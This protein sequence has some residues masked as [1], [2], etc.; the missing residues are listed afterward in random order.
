MT[1]KQIPGRCPLVWRRNLLAISF[2]LTSLSSCS[3][4]HQ[5]ELIPDQPPK[6]KDAKADEGPG[7]AGRWRKV[8]LSN[9]GSEMS[10]LQRDEITRLQAL[11][12][13][14]GSRKPDTDRVITVHE[15]E[16]VSAGLNFYASAH[17]PEAMLL[18]MD[19]NE[20]HRWNFTAIRAWPDL[21]FERIM[22]DKKDYWRRAHLFE[23]GDVLAISEGIGLL[24]IDKDSNLIWAKL[25]GAHHDL[26][27]LPNGD[28]YVLTRRV[29]I[30]PDWHRTVPVRE[31]YISLLDS[32]GNQQNKR[33]SLLTCLAKLH[34]E[35][36]YTWV[37]GNVESEYFD[38]LH[39]N[40]L[41]VLTG[42]AAHLSPSFT[43]G[44]ILVALR[45]PSLLAVVDCEQEKFVWY[46]AS[47]EPKPVRDDGRPR[48]FFKYQH[49]PQIIPGGNMLFFDNSGLGDQSTIWEF[50]PVTHEVHWF[51]RGT[52]RRPFYTE[53]CGTVQRLPNGNTLI[54]ESDNGRV[55]E[56]TREHNIVWEF[57]NP[58]RAGQDGKY[59][60]M[61]PEMVRLPPQ[62]P[63]P[64]ARGNRR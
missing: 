22:S 19:G 59:I 38:I 8:R 61:V 14:A 23:N 63:T 18:D 7:Q 51:F 64:W 6:E 4:P 11:G 37:P 15:R 36:N 21:P 5:T 32:S 43:M 57:Y 54:T 9:A 44:N 27:V 53:Y 45:T 34:G 52:N 60:A 29:H 35:I 24:K 58:H 42:Q 49:D 31:D 13:A 48:V 1:S 30:V 28:I 50:N 16:K 47:S 25:N 41:A 62:F 17:A 40:S 12:Y 33:V 20:L 26:E 46:F 39:T 10:T 2:I 56:V 3:N 55:L